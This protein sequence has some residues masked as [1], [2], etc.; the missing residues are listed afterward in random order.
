ML[1]WILT[2]GLFFISLP[3]YAVYDPP[4]DTMPDGYMWDPGI[5]GGI[6]SG[7]YSNV[8]CVAADGGDT[9]DDRSAIQSCIDDAS[10]GTAVYLPAGEY[11]LSGGLTMKSNVVLRG[12]GMTSTILRFTNSSNTSMV[13]FGSYPWPGWAN[14]QAI[15]SGYTKGSTTITVANSSAFSAGD[16]VIIAQ[17]TENHPLVDQ[18]WSSGDEIRATDWPNS[19]RSTWGMI[20]TVASVPNSTTIVLSDPF[21]VDYG[22]SYNPMIVHINSTKKPL[23]QN[24]GVEN[25][26][27]YRPSAPSSPGTATG[28]VLMANA[29]KCW[30]KNVEIYKGQGRVVYTVRSA[31]LEIHGCYL[32]EVWNYSSGGQGYLFVISYFTSN[33]LIENNIAIRANA[34]VHLETAGPGNVFAYN[35]FD[36]VKQDDARTCTPYAGYSIGSH[37]DFSHM[38]LLEG[39]QMTQMRGDC[40]H[41]NTAWWTMLRNNFD[42]TETEFDSINTCKETEWMACVRL[43]GC[44]NRYFNF[45]GNV[46]GKSGLTFQKFLCGS[47]AENCSN[48]GYQDRHI[49][50]FGDSDERTTAILHGNYDFYNNS[51]AHWEGGAD[52]SIRNSYYLSEKPSW[53][54]SI[55]WPPF[56]PVAPTMTDIPAIIYYET[57]AWPEESTPTLTIPGG[58]TISGGR[59][60]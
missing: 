52:H 27:M 55:T 31:R 51:I 10:S 34:T 33:T 22:S 60:E 13:T 5:P 38:V 50:S 16:F 19:L 24:S 36:S 17:E 58:V 54:G 12:A 43:F 6:P 56:D 1:I 4:A 46:L 8:T 41:G 23:I 3:C 11:Y 30:L 15:S 21:M 20:T 53:F 25:L 49:Y 29:Y 44:E 7:S 9:N 39:N 57:G 2:F 18:Q 32:H 26:K 37:S 59:V 48:Q 45:L 14:W 40:T 47:G 35:F 28:S 42:S